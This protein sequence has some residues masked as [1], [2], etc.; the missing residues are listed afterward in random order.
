MSVPPVW[1]AHS[2]PLD[3]LNPVSD[4]P[5]PSIKDCCWAPLTPWHSGSDSTQHVTGTFAARSLDT[6]RSDPLHQD[7][8]AFQDLFSKWSRVFFCRWHGL[9]SESSGFT[10]R[11][12][13]CSL[14]GTPHGVFSYYRTSGTTDPLVHTA[15]DCCRAVLYSGCRSK[16]TN[17]LFCHLLSW[18][19]RIA[20][21]RM[22]WLSNPK[23][24]TSHC[25]SFLV[26]GGTKCN[27]LSFT[28]RGC[29][30]TP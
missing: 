4:V 11:I 9:A 2:Y 15:R 1:S 18:R 23:W 22:C 26:V 24:S 12:S 13:Y 6:L 3:L 19:S 14:P 29:P 16:L 28:L 8:S 30:S 21:S 20:K 10:L 7:P 27:R 25:A 17:S 5:L